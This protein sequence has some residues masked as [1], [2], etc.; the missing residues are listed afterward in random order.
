MN[1]LPLCLAWMSGASCIIAIAESRDGR[2]WG[3]YAAFSCL[4]LVLALVTVV[5][6]L[7]SA[8]ALLLSRS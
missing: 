6:N 4:N 2:P 1:W 3:L 5:S 8:T 7:F